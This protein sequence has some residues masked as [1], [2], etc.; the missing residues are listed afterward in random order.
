MHYRWNLKE[1][2]LQPQKTAAEE[3]E[4]RWLSYNL[5]PRLSIIADYGHAF[6]TTV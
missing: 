4:T 3:H 5:M 1:D 2:G 6:M